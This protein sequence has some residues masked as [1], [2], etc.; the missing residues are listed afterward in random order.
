MQ[1]L[2]SVINKSEP[3]LLYLCHL[4]LLVEGFLLCLWREDYVTLHYGNPQ[5]RK[6]II[7]N[8][9]IDIKVNLSTAQN[10]L[11]SA[12]LDTVTHVLLSPHTGCFFC[13]GSQLAH[14]RTWHTESKDVLVVLHQ[15]LHQS[16]LPCSRGAAQ[17]HR[18]RSWHCSETDGQAGTGWAQVCAKSRLKSDLLCQNLALNRIQGILGWIILFRKWFGVNDFWPF[19]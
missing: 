3:E 10:L 7:R 13:D 11:A 6:W 1:I 18:P 4:P 9:L 17:H 2:Q 8:V 15:P 12:D 16:A 14:K 19:D 5:I